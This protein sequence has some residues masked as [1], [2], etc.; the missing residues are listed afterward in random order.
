M[1]GARIQYARWLWIS[2]LV[3]IGGVCL[4]PISL[5]QEYR[6]GDEV[7]GRRDAPL[8]VETETVVTVRNGHRLVVEDVR[9]KWP[10]VES[11]R[12]GG[13]FDVEGLGL[14]VAAASGELRDGTR[15]HRCPRR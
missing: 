11:M 10:W 9:G 15:R 13:V 7:N 6:K 8:K 5:G 12:V 14:Q 4:A 3:T 1:A 2:L